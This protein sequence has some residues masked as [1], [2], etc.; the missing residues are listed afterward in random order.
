MFS[1]YPRPAD[2]VRRNSGVPHLADIRIMGYSMRTARHRYSEWVAYDP[3]TFSANMSHVYARELYDHSND[4]EE[5]LNVVNQTAFK[6]VAAEL[7]HQLRGGWRK[8]LPRT[9]H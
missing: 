1:Q 4:P 9:L 3:T 6:G 7:A 5:N 8:A 2:S